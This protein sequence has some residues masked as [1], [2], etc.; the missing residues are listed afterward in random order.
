MQYLWLAIIAISLLPVA[1]AAFLAN[2]L[3]FVLLGAEAWRARVDRLYPYRG[4]FAFSIVVCA[5]ATAV[6]S[7]RYG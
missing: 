7:I 4:W 5:F 1:M 2:P 3:V 6:Y